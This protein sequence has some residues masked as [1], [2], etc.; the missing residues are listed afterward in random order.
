[1]RMYHVIRSWLNSNQTEVAAR[2]QTRVEAQEY[3]S[4]KY[5]LYAAHPEHFAS[6]V[7]AD[8]EDY[9]MVKTRTGGPGSGYCISYLD[10]IEVDT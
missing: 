6:A 9:L 7:I 4:R 2:F 1:M 8:A 5:A 10:L 3:I